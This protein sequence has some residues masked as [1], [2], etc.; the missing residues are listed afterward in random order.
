MKWLGTVIRTYAAAE[1]RSASMS[2]TAIRFH[3][4]KS[5]N[6]A[7]KEALLGVTV[8]RT[9]VLYVVDLICD[10]RRGHSQG[11]LVGAVE[12]RAVAHRG[13]EAV[14]GDRGAPASGAVR[15]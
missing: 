12:G 4:G 5:A 2:Q 7:H 9:R 10:V 15:S 14:R 3:L 8:A 11:F 13:E 1:K 6:R